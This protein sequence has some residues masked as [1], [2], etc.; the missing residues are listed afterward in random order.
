MH[1]LWKQ[2]GHDLPA[3]ILVDAALSRLREGDHRG[4]R[5]LARASVVE[6]AELL[7]AACDRVDRFQRDFPEWPLGTPVRVEALSV[8]IGE[9]LLLFGNPDLAFGSPPSPNGDGLYHPCAT[10]LTVA[11]PAE[12]PERAEARVRF[13]QLVEALRFGGPPKESLIWDPESGDLTLVTASQESLLASVDA[14][15]ITARRLRHMLAGYDPDLTAGPAC[16][17]CPRFPECPEWHDV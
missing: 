12:S 16:D 15:G 8:R 14:A 17:R 4:T 11:A 1:V 10:T 13:D 9:G 3:H 2:R 6:E 7:L 5:W